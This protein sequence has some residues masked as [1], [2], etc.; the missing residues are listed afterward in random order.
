MKEDQLARKACLFRHLHRPLLP[1]LLALLVL[2]LWAQ[3]YSGDGGRGIRL[4][5]LVRSSERQSSGNS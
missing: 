2:P 3:T 1:I 4:A 5:A